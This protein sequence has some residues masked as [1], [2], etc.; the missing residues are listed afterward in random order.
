MKIDV[1]HSDIKKLKILYIPAGTEVTGNN[2]QLND[3]D[4]RKIVLLHKGVNYDLTE[5]VIK[6]IQNKGYYINE[7]VVKIEIVDNK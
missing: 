4:F 7:T 1:Y 5:E 6:E 2:L 3:P